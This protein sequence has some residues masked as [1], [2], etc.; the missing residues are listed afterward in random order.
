MKKPSTRLLLVS[1]IICVLAVTAAAV[2]FAREGFRHIKPAVA[3]IQ[4]Q[5]DWQEGRFGA[6]LRGYTSAYAMAI[7]AGVRWTT[8]RTYIDQMITDRE[9]EQL[10][11]A[12]NACSGAVAILHGYDDEGS[13]GYECF[14][15]EAEIQRQSELK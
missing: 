5:Q 2:G 11:Q 15:L 13:L 8:A 1:I 4:A 12:L 14:A 10:D 3:V 7:E 6:S 9:A